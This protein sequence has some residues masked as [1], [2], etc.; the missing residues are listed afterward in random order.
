M[1]WIAPDVG[2]PL[3]L[4]SAL[5]APLRSLCGALTPHLL[6]GALAGHRAARD[7]G[8][9]LLLRPL[10]PAAIRVLLHWGGF[11]PVAGNQSRFIRSDSA[12]ALSPRRALGPAASRVLLHWSGFEPV[13]GND[14]RFTRDDSASALSSRRAH[15]P[16][17]SRGFK[18]NLFHNQH[19]KGV[20]KRTPLLCWLRRR[21]LNPRPSD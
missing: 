2:K 8:P 10:G 9:P 21:D 15:R 4:G 11:E 14:S 19:S 5:A 16:A 17:A 3:A 18:S 6:C 12:C 1:E 20:P 7:G 13:A